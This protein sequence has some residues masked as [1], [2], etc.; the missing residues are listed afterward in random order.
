MKMMK[1]L[2]LILGVLFIAGCASTKCKTPVAEPVAMTPVV[3]AVAAPVV[4]P[5]A[6]AAEEPETEKIPAAVLK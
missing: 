4:A 1:V 3:A 5:E 6:P 2:S